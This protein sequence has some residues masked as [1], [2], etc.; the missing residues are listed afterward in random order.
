MLRAA[1]HHIY[2]E[3]LIISLLQSRKFFLNVCKNSINLHRP[4]IFTRTRSRTEI[5]NS[6]L[7]V[8]ESQGTL[9]AATQ[10]HHH[11]VYTLNFY[12]FD[13]AVLVSAIII[14]APQTIDP[15]IIDRALI[16]LREGKECME[17][18][19]R[20]VGLAAKG[21]ALLSLLLKKAEKSVEENAASYSSSSGFSSGEAHSTPVSVEEE[22]PEEQTA[23]M[24]AELM[25]AAAEPV[26]AGIFEPGELDE[27]FMQQEPA[28][29]GGMEWENEGY[30]Q[31]LLDV[32]FTAEA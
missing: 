28:T 20:T 4:F 14:T 6:G 1:S 29:G 15:H 10:E 12:T 26:A 25:E 5:M 7:E 11:T 13:P 21:A 8:L 17:H 18:L 22:L 30:W 27:I 3:T 31:A 9:R 19:G 2:L 32:P 23:R 16:S 24:D